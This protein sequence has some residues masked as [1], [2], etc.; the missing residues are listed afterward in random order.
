MSAFA[1]TFLLVYAGLG[2][3]PVGAERPV[4][5]VALGFIV[6][7]AWALLLILPGWLWSPHGKEQHSVAAVYTA[8]AAKMSAMP[9]SAAA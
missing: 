2:L 6:G 8:L 1:N 7:G 4:W 5:H 9:S 3:G